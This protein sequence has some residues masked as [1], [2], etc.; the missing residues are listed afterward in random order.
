MSEKMD[1]LWDDPANWKLGRIYFCSQDPR[2]VVRGRDVGPIWTPNF[3]HRG[4][5]LVVLASVGIL[6]GGQVVAGAMG[7]GGRGRLWT[8]GI[9]LSLVFGLHAFI[10]RDSD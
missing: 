1:Q 4:A 6:L 8:I 3:A 7:A 5:W 2:L 9:S 10:G